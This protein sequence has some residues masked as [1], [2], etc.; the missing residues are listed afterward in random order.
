M[1]S[2]T[3]G[4]HVGEVVEKH[5]ACAHFVPHSSHGPILAADI[6]PLVAKQHLSLGT[7]VQKQVI[8]F[9]AVLVHGCF[10]HQTVQVAVGLAG[11]ERA[12]LLLCLWAAGRVR[13]HRVLH[14]VLHRAAPGSLILEHLRQ[15]PATVGRRY[16]KPDCFPSLL[17]LLFQFW[18]LHWNTRMS[19]MFYIPFRKARR[20]LSVL[21]NYQTIISS[22]MCQKELSTKTRHPD[23]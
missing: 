14:R 5:L 15:D 18:P 12:T 20:A 17:V 13:L 23:G 7:G 4:V 3:Y 19:H 21:R 8:G 11:G 6:D 22:L 1:H 9:T 10:H 2:T 16:S